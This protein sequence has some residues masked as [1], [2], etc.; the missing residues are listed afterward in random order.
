M[1]DF[2]KVNNVIFDREKILWVAH[3]G[4]QKVTIRFID[5]Q[6]FFFEGDE[7]VEAWRAF[8]TDTDWR[9]SS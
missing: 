7:A 6:D 2:I 4:L 5:G 1:S 3:F 9:D 8:D